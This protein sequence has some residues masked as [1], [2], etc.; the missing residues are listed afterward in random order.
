MPIFP[1]KLMVPEQL[2]AMECTVLVRFTGL[3]DL[4]REWKLR[5]SS[6]IHRYS[7]E[8][9]W[10]CRFNK[11][12][13]TIWILRWTEKKWIILDVLKVGR[14]AVHAFRSMIRCR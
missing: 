6:V 5:I 13:T 12:G 10:T 3:V 7:F 8:R 9:Y 1:F 11:P 4:N 2:L 14:S